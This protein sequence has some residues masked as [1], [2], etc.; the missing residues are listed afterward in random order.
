MSASSILSKYT[1]HSSSVV[2]EIISSV[3]WEREEF[4][5]LR[6]ITKC[7]TLPA[8][9]DHLEASIGLSALWG[10]EGSSFVSSLS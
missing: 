4:Q 2:A 3:K 10:L 8:L 9:V 6:E 7:A 5:K 1:S